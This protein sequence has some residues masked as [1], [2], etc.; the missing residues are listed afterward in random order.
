MSAGVETE[1]SLPG[2]DEVL[3]FGN[4]TYR[5]VRSGSLLAAVRSA[6]AAEL[7][8]AAITGIFSPAAAGE[9]IAG[10][11]GRAG[12]FRLVTKSGTHLVVRRGH[13]GGWMQN[14]SADRY[15]CFPGAVRTLRPFVELG[16]TA[17]LFLRG[18]RV[19]QPVFAAALL[20]CGGWMYR[21]AFATVEAEGVEN[22]L[23]AALSGRAADPAVFAWL[24]QACF[25]A[26]QEAA[27]MLRAGVMHP[28]LH[29]G[30][31]LVED[32]GKALLI[33]FDRAWSFSGERT[34]AKYARRLSERWRRACEKYRLGPELGEQFVRG[35]ESGS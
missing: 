19:A 31:V 12:A 9:P 17:E 22:L 3:S 25:H 5:L 30:N 33:D 34:A 21:T 35:L 26:G 11:A 8:A 28:D 6:Y 15:F 29:P 32:S 13:R 23:T 18:V 2:T 10:A 27:L 20:S 16:I 1:R 14:L 24:S 4:L 7:S